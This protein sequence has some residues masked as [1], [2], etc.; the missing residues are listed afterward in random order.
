MIVYLLASTLTG[1]FA[2]LKTLEAEDAG[3][4]KE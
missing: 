1:W 2:S 3:R 4:L